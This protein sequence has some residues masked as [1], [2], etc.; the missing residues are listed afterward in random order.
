MTD[1]EWYAAVPVKQCR[2]CGRKLKKKRRG[3]IGRECRR[4]LK[5]GYAG[6]QLKAFEETR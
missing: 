1:L 4:K 3:D 6:I 2:V 5:E